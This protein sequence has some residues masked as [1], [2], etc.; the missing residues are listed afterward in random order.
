MCSLNSTQKSSKK[1]LVPCDVEETYNL[2]SFPSEI[3]M[4]V[5]N[6]ILNGN[7]YNI[8]ISTQIKI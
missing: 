6:Q 3:G 5:F 8:K 1:T 4:F 2:T 7:Y